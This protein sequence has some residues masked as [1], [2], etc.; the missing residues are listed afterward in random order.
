[1]HLE[2]NDIVKTKK[3]LLID[4]DE[5]IRSALGYYFNKKA[6]LFNAFDN[7]ESA[8]KHI[9]EE[10]YDVVICDYKLPG[11]NGIIFFKKLQEL[12]PETIKILITAYGDDAIK[13]EANEIG[14]NDIIEKPFSANIIEEAVS[15]LIKKNDQ[16]KSKF[17]H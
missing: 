3:I 8:L 17:I 7:A 1:M 14:L 2:K 5:W 12:C 15:N 6:S 10:F 11:M 4:D 16:Q 13:A 9:K